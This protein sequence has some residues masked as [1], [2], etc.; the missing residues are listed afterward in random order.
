MCDSS[1]NTQCRLLSPVHVGCAVLSK[2]QGDQELNGICPTFLHEQS[3]TQ[4]EIAW[5]VNI[6]GIGLRMES[7]PLICRQLDRRP[8]L[9]AERLLEQLQQHLPR[10]QVP[11]LQSEK[12]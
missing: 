7:Q 4:C 10:L 5:V 11:Q 1:L 3:R 2:Q 8:S 6:D 12:I 9:P